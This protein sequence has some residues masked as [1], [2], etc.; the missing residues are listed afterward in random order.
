[1]EL[2][3]RAGWARRGPD[4][5]SVGLGTAA[6]RPPL[7]SS[8]GG[9][10]D[11]RRH[12]RLNLNVPIRFV[13]EQPK[14]RDCL[15]GQGLLKNI[16][17]GGVLF[18]VEPPLALRR[19]HVREFSFYLLPQIQ[20][21]CDLTHFQ[22]RG[23]VLRIEPPAQNSSA[24]RVAVQFL[25]ALSMQPATIKMTVSPRLGAAKDFSR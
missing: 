23:L 21:V 20:P 4:F 5:G 10:M 6:L 19:G 15:A 13:V 7:G 22:A 9:A 17:Y 24:Y 2:S 8:K 3:G 16:S 14:K 11:K 1:M 18:L 25:S 12:P